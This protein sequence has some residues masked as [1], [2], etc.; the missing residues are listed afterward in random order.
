LA[1]AAIWAFLVMVA[2]GRTNFPLGRRRISRALA[3]AE[4]FA[5]L[6]R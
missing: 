2:A 5:Q 6:G 1:F 3:A 4:P